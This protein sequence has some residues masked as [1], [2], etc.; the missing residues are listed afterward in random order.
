ML[1]HTGIF[2]YLARSLS[3]AG[4]HARNLSLVTQSPPTP[5]PPFP[6]V[7]YSIDE[8]EAAAVC[9]VNDIVGGEVDAWFKQGDQ[10]PRRR[11]VAGPRVAKSTKGPAKPPRSPP[12]NRC[13]FLCAVVSVCMFVYASSKGRPA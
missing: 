3:L 5:P 9:L 7:Q 1:H 12:P 13:R 8:V 11:K 4:L 10:G 6:A 2:A